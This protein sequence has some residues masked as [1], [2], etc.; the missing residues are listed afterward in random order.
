MTLSESYSDLRQQAV[1]Q[2][3]SRF[4]SQNYRFHIL[5]KFYPAATF[6]FKGIGFNN[7]F[8]LNN[9][10]ILKTLKKNEHIESILQQNLK[11]TKIK[12]CT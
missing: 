8:N 9:L 2:L 5:S 11:K 7:F 3:S 10:L 12:D 1:L 4:K 6:K